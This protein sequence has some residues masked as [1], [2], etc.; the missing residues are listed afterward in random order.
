MTT[1]VP[2]GRALLERMKLPR[3][4]DETHKDD[5][6]CILIVGGGEQVPGATIL[7]GVSALRVG[8]GKLQLAV[9][10]GTAAAVACA[11][12]EAMVRS[13]PRAGSGDIAAKAV[14]S[15]VGALD[16]MDAIVIG[17]GTLEDRAAGELARKLLDAATDIPCVIDAAAMTGL[18]NKGE[19]AQLCKGRAVLTPHPGEMEKLLDK[20]RAVILDDPQAAALEAA[21]KFDAVVVL[22]NAK[23]YIADPDGRCW[24]N[25][26][27]V[28]GLATS[29]SGDVLA[30][31]IGGLLARG[32]SP[33]TAAIWGVFLHA[34]AGR[35]LAVQMAP[36]GF[37]ARE[38]L[39]RLPAVL[40]EAGGI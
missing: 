9:T 40:A 20:S 17:P 3:T 22:K 28:A 4:H 18:A 8:A 31:I 32:A 1:P 35:R 15:L 10:S 37:L 34:E 2:I 39:D 36:I 25:T 30:G 16:H 12:P 7:A 14:R 19:A 29:G 21:A 23:T 38:L 26:G 6:G 11:V 5:R 33:A 27:G 13:L 24:M